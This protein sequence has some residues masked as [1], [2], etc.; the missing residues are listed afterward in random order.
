MKSVFQSQLESTLIVDDLLN[1]ETEV[2]SEAPFAHEE[3]LETTTGKGAVPAG[4]EEAVD[5][6]K[7]GRTDL[8]APTYTEA[9]VMRTGFPSLLVQNGTFEQPKLQRWKDVLNPRRDLIDMAIGNVGRVDLVNHPN[10]KWVGTAWRIN[11]DTFVTNRHVAEIFAESRQGGWGVMRGVTAYVDLC[12]EHESDEQLGLLV[13]SILHIEALG[14]PD[15]AIMRVD[16]SALRDMADPVLLQLDGRTPDVIGVIGYPAK[17]VRDNPMDAMERYFN[18]IYDVK[19]F[20]PGEVMDDQFSSTV[21]THNCTTLGGNSGS[22]VIDVE[23][24]S[25]VGLH[26]AGS[27]LTQNYAVRIDAVADILTRRSVGFSSLGAGSGNGGGSSEAA[28]VLSDREGYQPD[29]LGTGSLRVPLPEL[30]CLQEHKLARTETGETE[31]KY[32]HFS[33]VMNGE[34]RL[35]YYAAANIDGDD[36]RR[37]RRQRSFRLDP[38]LDTDHQAG[39]DLYRSNPLDRGHLIRRLDPCWGTRAEAEQANRDSMFFPNIGPQHKD[40][41]QKIWLQLEEHIL[42]KSDDAD[43]RISVFVGCLFDD[44]DPEHKPTGIRVPMGFWKVVASIGRV[45][46]GRSNHRVL[47]AQAFILFQG[48]LVKPQDLE[49]VFGRGFEEHQVTVEE[50]ERLTGHDFGLLRDADTFAVTSEMRTGRRGRMESV[51]GLSVDRSDHVRRL[52]SLDDIVAD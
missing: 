9:I 31:L 13:S 27:A 51:A 3:G 4:L 19:R 17:A 52:H 49:L 8:T 33:V 5:R 6:L 42:N 37:P 46:R 45:Q 21:F 43:A 38:R 15:V 44:D 34:R 16:G 29:F 41:N 20:A 2:L 28:G 11:E 39:E 18:D 26:Y 36:L 24:G 14:L 1:K 12:E 22:V 7:K 50:L 32:M 10:H 35:A 30:N 23:T 40:L 48:H 25:A 47:Q